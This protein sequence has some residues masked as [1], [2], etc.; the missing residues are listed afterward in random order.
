MKDNFWV[1][2]FIFLM[3]FLFFYPQLKI[4]AQP[5]LFSSDITISMDFKDASLKDVLKALSI[6]SG[7]NFIAS[8]AVE[9]R[10]LTL[11]LDK[12]PLKE[13]MDKIFK[14]NN[15]SYELD[16]KANI[17]L[18][19]DWGKPSLE[20]I[21][22]V[23][24]LKHATVSSSSLKEEMRNNLVTTTT[25]GAPTGGGGKWTAETE[26]G[27]TQ[28]VKKVL[29]SYGS[30]VED[31]RTNS[32]IVTDI[33]SQMPVI[34]Q[35]ISALDVPVPQAMLEVE[36]LD[37]NKNV[38]DQLGINWPTTLAQLTVSGSRITRFPFGNKGTSGRGYTIDPEAGVFGGPGEGWDFA[39]WPASQFGPSIITIL[40][41]TLTLDFL[42]SQ[43]DTKTLARPR[44]L[45]LN[46]EPAE[47]KITSNEAIGVKV[48]AAGEGAAAQTTYEAERT[49]TGVSLRV[50]PQINSETGEITL[51][52]T[53]IVSE[54]I[55]GST[56]LVSQQTGEVTF[57]NPEQRSTK[58][59]VKVKDGETIIL[60]GLIRNQ[61][62]TT[63]TKVPLLGDIPILGH[64]FKHTTR[65]PGRERELLVFITPHIVKEGV[66]E[67]AQLKAPLPL[68]REQSLNSGLSRQNAINHSLNRF[69]KK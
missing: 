8:Q 17:F 14:A 23:F 67:L 20:T 13:A 30:L 48:T 39:A 49:E 68:E 63:V 28:A 37:V 64:L 19:K 26:S 58:S 46:N 9:D 53:P 35:V 18:V 10:I 45:T 50:T 5:E 43:T 33:P 24:Y 42:R 41:T 7:M 25:G 59:M 56:F 32:L 44:I 27:I 55:A 22:K 12:V 38:V 3:L 62:T 57:L 54:A 1:R 6:Q 4:N 69:E 34:T 36:M 11:Y 15:L 2:G 21:T 40:G 61:T 52:L 47:I 51:F 65:N 66:V 16:K 60:G 31:Y 29:T